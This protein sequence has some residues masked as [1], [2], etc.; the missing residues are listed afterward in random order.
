MNHHFKVVYKKVARRQIIESSQ[1]GEE[2]MTS[3]ETIDVPNIR[4]PQF[5]GGWSVFRLRDIARFSK[6]K[7]ISKDD[8]VPNGKFEAIRYGELYTRYREAIKSVYSRTDL[9]G[10]DL[11]FSAKNDIIIPASGETNVDIATASCVL[12]DGVALGGD[13]NIIR[14]DADGVFQ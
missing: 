7:N 10:R 3:H 14:T 13:I 6:G 1:R 11:V 8:I 12:K 2:D 4:F 9:D 5:V